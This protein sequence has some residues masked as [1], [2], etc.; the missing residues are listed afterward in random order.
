[1]STQETV[2]SAKQRGTRKSACDAW[3][4]IG[5]CGRML[6]AKRSSTTGTT[7]HLPA[8]LR[9]VR[10]PDSGGFDSSDAYRSLYHVISGTA[11]RYSNSNNHM[12]DIGPG[13]AAVCAREL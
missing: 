13:Q 11:L 1:M 7:R 3:E 6:Q 9:C 2:I 12:E 4:S 10:S 5:R 8:R